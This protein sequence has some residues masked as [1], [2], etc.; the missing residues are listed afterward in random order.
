MSFSIFSAGTALIRSVSIGVGPT[1][2]TVKPNDASSYAAICVK[3]RTAA[4][5]AA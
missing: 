4:F 2:L 1:A 5:E 3:D